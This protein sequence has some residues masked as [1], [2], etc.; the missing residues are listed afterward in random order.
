MHQH[1]HSLRGKKLAISIF[2]NLLITAG[3]VVGGFISGSMALLSDALHNFSDV[4][5]LV[6][7]YIASVL[8]LKEQN[9]KRTFGYKRAEII[10]A[11][12][13]ASVLIVIAVY[14]SIEAYQRFKEPQE[15]KSVWVISLAFFSIILNGISV[16]ILHDEKT[17]SM[18]IQSAYIHLFSDMLTSVA[19]LLGGVLIYYFQVYW[20]DAALTLLIAVYIIYSTWNLLIDSLKVLMLFTPEGIAVEQISARI[21]VLPEVKNIH[22]VH[23]WQLND[24]QIHFEAHIDFE[25]NL[26]LAEV[27]QILENIKTTLHTEFNIDHA[28]LQ[29][30]YDI[31]H[32]K[33]LISDS[34]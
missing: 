19:V 11:F 25:S 22:H 5:A 27:N 23:I 7:S 9:V 2:L 10:A 21:T 33:R 16:W 31:C 30:E 29:P 24:E 17:G 1:N 18:N 26:K 32:D 34:H 15:I 6:I 12:V 8:S 20:I 4:L 14:L 28:T 3:Q 13:N